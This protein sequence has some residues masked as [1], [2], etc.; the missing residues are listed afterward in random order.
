MFASAVSAE[1][2][3]EL[4]LP[5][6]PPEDPLPLPVP[7]VSRQHGFHRR[8]GKKI[9]TSPIGSFAKRNDELP[10]HAADGPRNNFRF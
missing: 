1:G 10:V 6:L 3:E 7:E 5:P 2:G 4:P 8:N 9:E